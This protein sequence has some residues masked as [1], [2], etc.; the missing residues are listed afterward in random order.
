MSPLHV[1]EHKLGKD[2]PHQTWYLNCLMHLDI[3]HVQ[4]RMHLHDH[5]QDI[6]KLKLNFQNQSK[7][8]DEYLS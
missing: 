5:Q 3:F 1:Q 2:R 8:M 7:Q 4:H 6:G